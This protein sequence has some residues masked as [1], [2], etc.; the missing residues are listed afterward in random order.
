MSVL[1]TS[2]LFSVVK[3]TS[4]GRKNFPFLPPH[5]KVLDANEEYAVFG[6]IQSAIQNGVDRVSSRQNIRSF[7]RAIGL[8]NLVIVHTPAVIVES[9]NG[10]IKMLHMANGGT[11][12]ATDPCWATSVASEPDAA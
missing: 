5:G 3:N 12:S 10:T 4:G 11:L 2:C 1:D 8:G 7:E 9:P 6:S